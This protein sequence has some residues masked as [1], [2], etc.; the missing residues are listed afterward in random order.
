MR[1]GELGVGEPVPNH[2]HNSPPKLGNGSE[3]EKK[4]E[5]LFLVIYF[6]MQIYTTHRL[7]L[8]PE[9][10]REEKREWL[11]VFLVILTRSMQLTPKVGNG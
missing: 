11:F 10:I 4:R 5:W 7:K 3:K 2:L 9:W 1:I 6:D 8:G